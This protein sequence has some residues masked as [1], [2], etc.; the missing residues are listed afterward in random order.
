MVVLSVT[1]HSRLSVLTYPN[2]TINFNLN[3]PKNVWLSTALAMLRSYVCMRHKA[4]PVPPTPLQA[5]F[6]LEPAEVL[7]GQKASHGQYTYPPK[8]GP[9]VVPISGVLFLNIT[10]TH[11]APFGN[12]HLPLPDGVVLKPHHYFGF[13]P[14]R[15]NLYSMFD[16]R[17]W[18]A[19][20]GMGD[21][22]TGWA[23]AGEFS[24]CEL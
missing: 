2:T 16:R 11:C 4:D 15:T 8:G 5:G 6:S 20:L 19:Y 13:R 10:A 23:I 3:Q 12:S 17:N 1:P 22:S 14:E 18:A 24:P 9:T 7:K 21:E